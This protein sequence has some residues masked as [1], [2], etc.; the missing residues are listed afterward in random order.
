MTD[1]TTTPE[2]S[3]AVD[4]AA[5]PIVEAPVVEVPA[6]DDSA[7][8][9]VAEVPAADDS[10]EVEVPAGADGSVEV[11]VPAGDDSAEVPVAEV[12]AADDSAEVEVPAGAEVDAPSDDPAPAEEPKSGESPPP[13]ATPDAVGGVD[14]ETQTSEMPADGTG[15][16]APGVPMATE[17]PVFVY[18]PCD[19]LPGTISVVGANGI[20]ADLGEGAVGVI[21]RAELA[22]A[23]EPAV[24]DA[25]E[26]TVIKLQTGTGRY[27]ISPKRAARTRAWAYHRRS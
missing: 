19:I 26:G 1:D 27:V 13:A 21:P 22:S 16:T 25:V 8:V 18:Q 24:G 14:T 9:P 7:E 17:A 3:S 5:A 6:G 20:E 23:D 12:P 2:D 10:V 4:A 15:E 11:E